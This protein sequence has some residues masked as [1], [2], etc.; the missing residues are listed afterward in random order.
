MI[1]GWDVEVWSFHI[2]NWKVE[3]DK[4]SG[5]FSLKEEC[6]SEILKKTQ[7]LVDKKGK[8]QLHVFVMGS[9]CRI[10]KYVDGTKQHF[11]YFTPR[12][13]LQ[14]INMRWGCPEFY[15]NYLLLLVQQFKYSSIFVLMEK[16]FRE[17][18]TNKK[19][20]I[21]PNTQHCKTSIQLN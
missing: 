6:G 4:D 8:S 13:S 12:L 16:L 19:Y 17:R 7:T 3:L 15:S 18:N 5:D 20:L 1:R 21:T 10:S 14:Q 11:C 2:W 9:D